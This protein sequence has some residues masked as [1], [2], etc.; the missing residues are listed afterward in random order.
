MRFATGI[1]GLA[2]A[3]CHPATPLQISESAE[4]KAGFAQCIRN[5]YFMHEVQG[6]RPLVAKAISEPWDRPAELANPAISLIKLDPAI[7]QCKA[8]P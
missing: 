5:L 1:V 2:L 3:A 8:G 6:I 7:R 4:I